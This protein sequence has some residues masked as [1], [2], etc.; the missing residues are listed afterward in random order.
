MLLVRQCDRTPVG[1]MTMTARRT[2][3]LSM[4]TASGA[5]VQ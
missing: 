5:R 1:A 2:H 4:S 3:R